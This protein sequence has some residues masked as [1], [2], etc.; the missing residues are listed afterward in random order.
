MARLFLKRVVF[1]CLILMLWQTASGQ[2]PI[3][4]SGNEDGTLKTGRSAVLHDKSGTLSI[5]GAEQALGQGKFSA[6]KSAGSTR[7]KPGAHWSY[8]QLRNTEAKPVSLH[9]EYVDHQL[10]DLDAFARATDTGDWSQIAA[11]SMEKPFGHR[12]VE[13]NRFVVPVTLEANQTK[14]FLV[15]FG[16]RERGYAF[17]SMRIWSPDNLEMQY[18]RES[19]MISFLFGGF[20]LMGLFALIAGS[21]ARNKLLL[22]YSLYA[23]SKITCWATIL[24]YTHQFVLR[25][26]FHWQLMSIGGAVTILL[27]HIFARTFLQT[28]QYTPRLDY[29]V[30]AMIANAGLLLIAAVFQVKAVA[31]VTITLALLMYPVIAVIAMLRW[32]QGQAEAGIFAIAWSFLVAGLIMQALRDLGVV[33]HSLLNYYWPPVASFTEMLTVMFALGYKMRRL[34]Q[35]KELTEQRYLDHLV[36][37]KSELETEVRN[38][39]RELEQAKRIAEQEARTDSL[40]GI[41]NRR[42][43]LEDARLRLKLAKRNQKPCCLFMFDLDHF[44]QINDTRGHGVG[45]AVLCKFTETVT[46]S[47]RETD[48][49]GRLGGEEFA[50]L[51]EE[52][53][54]A[55]RALAERLRADTAHINMLAN[56]H[57]VH[58]T[59]SIGLAFSD[60]DSTVEKLLQQADEA[61]Y[62]AKLEGRNRV[63]A[64]SQ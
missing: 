40:T 33:E 41:L 4:V 55:A 15:R 58:V 57:E 48:V 39:T 23:F 28:R 13:H 62:R 14:E 21:V 43:F 56:N 51:V 42:S 11:L 53:E 50:L 5:V 32:R 44:K 31:L 1:A 30:L 19:T 59:T 22:I 46:K 17:P 10:I 54:N 8:F 29:L 64:A 2:T 35:D 18:V 26:S 12:L 7:L 45:D 16:S 36:K 63:V 3:T 9:L 49:F 27:G 34:Y 60:A 25:E 20:F 6:L 52:P 47:I 61:M 38:R 24:G 37:S